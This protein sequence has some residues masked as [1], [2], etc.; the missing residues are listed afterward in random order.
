MFSA[1]HIPFMQKALIIS[2]ITGGFL[3]FLGVYIVLR[4]I[5]FVGI[6]LSQITACGFAFGFLL[7][8]NPSI[9]AVIFTLIGVI[10]FSVRQTE[11]KIPDESVIGL[12][13][14]LASSLGILFI[15]KS[16]QAET[17]I[18][19][20]LSGSILTVTDSQIYVA[21][22]VFSLCGLF[23]YLFYKQFIFISFDSETAATTGLNIQLWNFIFY[24]ILGIVISTSIKASG[25]I[26]TFGYMVIPSIIAL[27]IVRNMKKVFFISVIFG[28]IATLFGLYLSFVL[29]LPSGPTIVTILCILLGL[30]LLIK[31]VWTLI[32]SR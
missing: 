2:L 16:A 1:F 17:H 31:E 9:C 23:H 25:V 14:A 3:S 8:I 7:S 27:L 5:V 15:A 26:L 11:K 19:N 32:Y 21:L 18:L 20:L 22:I 4:R 28:L 24:L 29:D 12:A 30:S 10:L 6:A 13:Y